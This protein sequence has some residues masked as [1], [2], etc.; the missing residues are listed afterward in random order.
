VRRIRAISHGVAD[1]TI[2]RVSGRLASCVVLLLACGPRVASSP[3]AGESSGGSESGQPAGEGDETSGDA[4]S[5]S[6]AWDICP[7]EEI[8]VG[9]TF[10]EPTEPVAV[11]ALRES[12]S[13]AEISADATSELVVHDGALWYAVRDPTGVDPIHLERWSVGDDAFTSVLALEVGQE[14]DALAASDD[15]LLLL[16]QADEDILARF[17][18]EG[19]LL[20]LASFGDTDLG[21]LPGDEMRVG[22]GR[23]QI[24]I[25]A[26]DTFEAAAYDSRAVIDVDLTT[27]EWVL[28]DEP[29]AGFVP[30]EGGWWGR[31]AVIDEYQYCFDY[32]CI[33]ELVATHWDLLAL[34]EV[35]ASDGC[36][37]SEFGEEV[38]DAWVRGSDYVFVTDAAARLVD[39]NGVE[40]ELWRGGRIDNAHLDDAA[41][42]LSLSYEVED[43]D[44]PGAGRNELLR[45]D[46]DTGSID[47]LLSAPVDDRRRAFDVAGMLDTRLYLS[48]PR[49]DGSGR[50]EALDL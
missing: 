22:G 35:V 48:S 46:L 4:S 34:G 33:H 47:R 40:R 14:L 5:S 10:C 39:A 27:G 21:T 26:R 2:D 38:D 28:L 17:T 30:V 9:W 15:G 13:L 50:L 18:S 6:G 45:V 19:G 37:E 23:V 12:S 20:E 1:A 31:R 8:R 29:I 3:S 44:N 43:P 16:I 42:F 49:P 41:L 7:C 36:V 32:S 11:D 24:G 25:D